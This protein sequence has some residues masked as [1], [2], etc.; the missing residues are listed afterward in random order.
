[1][2]SIDSITL[3]APDP[4]AARTF[5]DE[6]FSLDGLID[7]QAATAP[8]SGFRGYT[9]S[10]LVAQPADADA[11]IAS[12]LAAGAAP[13]KPAAR[14]LWGYGGVVQAPDGA[15]W[16]VSTSTKKNTGPATRRIDQVVLLLGVTDMTA[17]K[18]FYVEHG[19]TV[20]KSFGRKYVEFAMPSSVVTLALYGRRPLAKTAGVPADGDGSHRLV[21]VGDT[22]GSLTDPDGFRWDVSTTRLQNETH[23]S[24]TQRSTL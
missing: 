17:S 18:R 8:S 24:R 5:Y 4:D 16:Q 3:E 1:M 13:I 9:L 22:A 12:A 20:G 2:N 6:A 19:L 15:I 14:S 23:D 7:V 11:L 21:I 10:L